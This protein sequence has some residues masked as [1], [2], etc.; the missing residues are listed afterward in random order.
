MQKE[1]KLQ[2]IEKAQAY[3]LTNGLSQNAMAKLANINSSYMSS[4]FDS[5][6][7]NHP[8][9]NGKTTA[10]ADKW[11][12][13]LAETIGYK[14][15]KDYWPMVPTTQF[16]QIV[17]AMQDAK[18]NFQSRMIIGETGSGKTFSIQKFVKQN[19]QYTYVIT[20]SALYT[21]KDLINELCA[22]MRIEEKRSK[23]QNIK[24]IAEKLTQIRRNGG[25]PVIIID[26]AENLKQAALA[27]LKSLYDAVGRNAGI[28]LIGTN[29]LVE[30]IDRLRRRNKEGMPQFYRRFK[31]G[32]RILPDVDR[33]FRLFLEDRVQCKGL[34]KLL[35]QLCDNYGELND[36][37]EPAL[38]E[39]DNQGKVLTEDLFRII[40]NIN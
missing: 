28:V 25:S 7:E 11:F 29:Q 34:R 30:K 4:M 21:I 24:N 6:W 27:M 40:M 37:L 10:I 13:M 36:Y 17:A 3:M 33:S 8:S 23:A 22:A 35:T 19:P 26:E 20:A 18:Y 5:N 2:I 32:I 15:E 39:A 9:G 38:R 14:V 31:A 1:T 16:R 12:E